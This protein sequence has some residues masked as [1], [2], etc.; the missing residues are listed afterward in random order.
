MNTGWAS[1]HRSIEDNPLWLS[2]PFTKGQAWVDLVVFANHKKSFFF[3]RGNKV[4]IERGQ[5]GWSQVTMAKRW[6][7][8][9]KKVVNFLKMLKK[10]HQISYEKNSVTSII[11]I[12]N[13]EKYQSERA[14][15]GTTE[16]QQK[17]SRGYTNNNDNNDNKRESEKKRVVKKEI[18][19]ERKQLSGME[20]SLKD[21]FPLEEIKAVAEKYRVPVNTIEEL[22]ESYCL[23]I[24]EKPQDKNRHNRNLKASVVNWLRRD[25]KSGKIKKTP[26]QPIHNPVHDL[27]EISEEQRIENLK[28][29]EQIKQQFGRLQ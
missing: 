16:E 14:A 12:L 28:R 27:P 23:W 20:K 21:N 25:L 19:N 1:I 13:Y 29:I 9:R 26:L 7:W 17:S 18:D 15:E 2:E 22:K 5:I 8:S 4:E 24:Q 11:T 10:E 3:V 6:K